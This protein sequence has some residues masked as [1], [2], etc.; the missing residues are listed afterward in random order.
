MSDKYNLEEIFNNS[1][2]IDDI[3]SVGRKLLLGLQIA[4]ANLILT[5][6]IG[7]GQA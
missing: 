5:I 7:V 2:N 3:T 6:S 4:P 1:K